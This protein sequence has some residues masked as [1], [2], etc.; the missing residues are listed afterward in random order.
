MDSTVGRS[1]RALRAII[2]ILELISNAE[3]FHSWQESEVQDYETVPCWLCPHDVDSHDERARC[4]TQSCAC[5]WTPNVGEVPFGE[6][7]GIVRG[8]SPVSR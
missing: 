7:P 1:G 8:A 6:P 5:G 4:L 3:R 2:V